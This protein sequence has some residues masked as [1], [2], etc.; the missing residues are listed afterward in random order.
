MF[1]KFITDQGQKGLKQAY[2]QACIY[3]IA[4]TIIDSVLPDRIRLDALYVCCVLLIVGQPLKGVV[5]Y[6]IAACSLIL[7]AHLK[8]NAKLRLSWINMANAA[9]SI[10]AAL[11]T[12]YVANKILKKN[13]LLEH[14]VA[15]GSRNLAEVNKTLLKS[16]S[17]LRTIFKTTDIA[18]L[19]LD[20]NLQILTYNT[21]ANHWSEQSF[22]TQL[23]EGAY[24]PEL[25][26]EERKEPVSNMMYEAMAG[27]PINYEVYYPLL[28]GEPEWY[29]IS[30]HAVHDHQD[31]TIGLC[32]S[33]IN[34][35]SAKLAEIE[36]TRVTENLVQRNN[37]L[38][39]F[40]Y[41]VSHNLRMPLANITGLAQILKQAGLPLK[42]RAETEDFL[43]QSVMKL[44]EIIRDL[45]HI[46]QVRRE[47]KEKKEKIV[48]LE[49][50]TDILAA[51]NLVIELENIQV[52]TDFSEAAELFS[53]KA[54]LYSIFLNLVSNGIKYRQPDR[55]LIIEI[56]SWMEND[57]LV[58]W[59]KDN[60]R[61]I[62]LTRKINE[63]FGLYKRF[64]PDVE[65]KGMGLFMVKNQVTAL[66]GNIEVQSQPGTGTAFLIWLP[67][68]G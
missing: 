62:N 29:N 56:K 30:L 54:Y 57:K 24:F 66:G 5:I 10:I 27:D 1:R 55:P 11:I 51:F 50:F 33:V 49:L 48:L 39:Q 58:I 28:N 22:G 20:G 36:S 12:S 37:D 35:T 64:H 68:D 44:D 23:Q 42:E 38:E 67:Y 13:R 60:G 9:I 47:I 63:I 3:L 65:G 43:F 19:L 7:A 4:I 8:M 52:L 15:E 21:I 53:I 16:Q 40:S 14:S 26:N 32:C 59:F 41:I 2:I 46:L 61:G 31:K 18:F 45:N 6:S 17:H 34:I 25:L